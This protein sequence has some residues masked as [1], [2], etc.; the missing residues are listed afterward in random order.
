MNTSHCTRHGFTLVELLVVVNIIA[1]LIAL[2]LPAVQSAREAARQIQC[3][4]NLRQLALGALSHEQVHSHYPAGG[5]GWCWV[6]DADRGFGPSQP[7]GWIYNSLPFIEQ[8]TLHDLGRGQ[9]NSGKQAAAVKLVQTPISFLN[10][11]SRRRSILYSQ[12]A[13][14]TMVSFNAGGINLPASNCKVARSDYACNAGTTSVADFAGPA[15]LSIGDLLTKPA[16]SSTYYSWPTVGQYDGMIYCRSAVRANEVTDGTS[17]TILYGEK[18]LSPDYYTTGKDTADNENMYAG[19]D[20]DICRWTYGVLLPMQDRAGYTN[21]WGFGSSHPN[22]F[23]AA[24][25]DGSV[26]TI[27]YSITTEAFRRLGCR[28]DG[29]TTTW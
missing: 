29:L 19:F 26:H 8:E 28:S 6:G 14:G 3:Q 22:Y 17:N 5:W 25:C 11:P 21:S 13:N 12:N 27:A 9:N 24:F 10:C 16:S 23:H 7:G 4:N 20:N 2:L 18:Y 1:V 15:D